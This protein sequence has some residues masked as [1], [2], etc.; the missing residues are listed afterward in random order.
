MISQS[1]VSLQLGIEPLRRPQFSSVCI[2]VRKQVIA[3][4]INI[5]TAA[6]VHTLQ[7]R[8]QLHKKRVG[9]LL[10][11][12]I[13]CHEHPQK[14]S[15]IFGFMKNF[16]VRW[17]QKLLLWKRTCFRS[18]EKNLRNWAVS[19]NW[20]LLNWSLSR[21]RRKNKVMRI[22]AWKLHVDYRCSV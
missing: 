10:Q 6:W 5:K 19:H 16:L 15:E 11:N 4:L 3:S 8:L 18:Q 9:F 17:K 14:F 12:N 2:A 20:S 22:D 1:S 7:L 21:K 13:I